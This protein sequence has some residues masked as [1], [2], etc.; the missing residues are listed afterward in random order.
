MREP[1]PSQEV[2]SSGLFSLPRKNQIQGL[3]RCLLGP[4]KLA[5]F[6]SCCNKHN[7]ARLHSSYWCA[8]CLLHNL[9]D[10][11]AG[12]WRHS[13]LGRMD[14]F[15]DASPRRFYRRGQ[16]TLEE[17]DEMRRK[18]LIVGP[19]GRSERQVHKSTSSGSQ[20]HSPGGLSVEQLEQRAARGR[21]SWPA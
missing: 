4:N 16:D 12:S 13:V 5:P 6:S 10:P 21:G 7:L 20:H 18:Q 11:Q 1:W 3:G 8:L 14:I 2:R 15:V 19:I 9:L 17:E